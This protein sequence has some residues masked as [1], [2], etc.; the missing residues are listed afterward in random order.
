MNAHESS[1]ITYSQQDA[2]DARTEL[3]ALMESYPSTDEEKER[4]LGLFIRGSLLAR[5]L[6][7]GDLSLIHI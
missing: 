1:V 7:V 3:F 6:A 4:S 5:M 2:I